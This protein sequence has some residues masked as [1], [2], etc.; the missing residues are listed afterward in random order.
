MSGESEIGG[1]APSPKTPK[2]GGILLCKGNIN[3]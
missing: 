2:K 3:S 1:K